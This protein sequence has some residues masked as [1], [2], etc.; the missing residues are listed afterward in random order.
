MDPGGRHYPRKLPTS[1]LPAANPTTGMENC[2]K[3]PKT[4]S[5][6]PP[7][8]ESADF[9]LETSVR[10]HHRASEMDPGGRHYP[11][12]LPTSILPA[13]N[14]TTGMENCSKWPKTTSRAPP[15]S[16]SADFYLETSVR[17]HHRASEMDPEGRYHPRK[18]PTAS[19]KVAS[20][21]V[22]IQKGRIGTVGTPR[23]RNLRKFT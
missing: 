2:S 4:T 9:Y 6:A 21:A 20:P 7:G 19:H 15:G 8:S 12:K 3:W 13:A 14:P 23:G 22:E 10:N 11:R 1:I 16:E 17:N 18:P 5:R